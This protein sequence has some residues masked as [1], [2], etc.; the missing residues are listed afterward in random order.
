MARPPADRLARLERLA[1]DLG[2]QIQARGALQVFFGINVLPPERLSAASFRALWAGL[3]DEARAG[4]APDRFGV[5]LHIPFCRHKC[6]YC[7]YYSEAQ[8]AP[9]VIEAYLARLDAE[10]AYFAEAFRGLTACTWYLG[11]GTPT[12]L[13]ERQLDRLLGRLA[14]LFPPRDGGQYAFECS[15]LTIT[16]RKARLFKRHGFNRV[17]FGVQSVS[18][19]ILA[20]AGRGYQDDAMVARAF[21]V[22][23]AE[24]FWVNAD[25]LYGLAG[26]SAASVS[27]SLARVLRHGPDTVTLYDCAPGSPAGAVRARA[28]PLQALARRLAPSAAAA[29]YLLNARDPTCLGAVRLKHRAPPFVYDYSDFNAEP[30]SFLG[31]GP[32]ARSY[33]YGVGRGQQLRHR[34][35]AAF[36]PDAPACDMQRARPREEERRY[37]VYALEMLGGI[38]PAAVEARFGRFPAT[39]VGRTCATLAR[40][41]RL[42]RE[43]GIFRHATRSPRE[44]FVTALHFVDDGMIDAAARHERQEAAHGGAA[45]APTRITLA[46][47]GTRLAVAVDTHGAGEPCA[48]ACGGYHFLVPTREGAAPMGQPGANLLTVFTIYFD[49]LVR[50]GRPR[51]VEELLALL[52]EHQGALAVPG[53]AGRAGRVTIES[54][55]VR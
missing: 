3:A 32:E 1:D 25:L 39:L 19:A 49:Q 34:L 51:S 41:G 10:M 44:R 45:R 35:D 23:K 28:T 47:G 52:I 16:P 9:G 42:A 22:L 18:P 4:R 24:G 17:S 55:P 53:C 6:R 13:A 37:A 33:L 31:L 40:A 12:L 2:P 15:P 30:Y 8:A 36:D 29:G 38:D 46:Y 43:G 21:E 11:G 48:H 26:D 54:R 20:R 7:I 27:A 50:R 14:E 5:Y